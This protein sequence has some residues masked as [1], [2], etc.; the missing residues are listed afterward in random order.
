MVGQYHLPAYDETTV[1]FLRE[2]LAGRK[3]LFKLKDLVPVTVPRLTE[4][5]ADRLYAECRKN[6][7]SKIYQPDPPTD[8]VRRPVGRRFLFN[9]PPT[10]LV[11]IIEPVG[12]GHTGSSV[13]CP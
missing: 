6:E 1:H 2:C 4:F 11:L 13:L 8:S 10:A 7:N 12:D 9:V 3:R 5:Q